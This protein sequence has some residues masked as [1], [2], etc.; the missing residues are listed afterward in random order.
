MK[1]SYIAAAALALSSMGANA[2]L[3][4]AGTAC[5]FDDL[6]NVTVSDCAGYFVGNVN[7]SSDLPDVLTMLTS[8]F[9]GSYTGIL[10]QVNGTASSFT[11][12]VL[13]GLSG[14]TIVGIHW[15]GAA[16]GGVTGFYRFDAGLS[17]DELLVQTPN[18]P[19]KGV[20]NVAVYTSAP[21]P[22]PIPE[23]S[24][25]ALMLAGLG[26]VGLVARRRRVQK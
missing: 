25:Y 11:F 3:T 13:G 8:E 9:G 6:L 22:G 17:L 20:S 18:D 14:D 4:S 16:G 24:T 23:P 10:E 12:P 5:S 26:A 7:N 19:F 15:G 2:A 21:I 1:M